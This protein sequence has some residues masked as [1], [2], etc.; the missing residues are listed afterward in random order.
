[1]AD[2]WLWQGVCHAS[3]DDA[4]NAWGS[5]LYGIYNGGVGYVNGLPFYGAGAPVGFVPFYGTV[6]II[7]K[8][9]AGVVQSVI[10]NNLFNTCTLL[11]FDYPTAMG[12]FSFS[13]CTIFLIWWFCRYGIRTILDVINRA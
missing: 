3:S 1:V 6:E 4:L 13:F 5:T 11:A 12:F 2:G 9:P 7:L 10:T 8:N